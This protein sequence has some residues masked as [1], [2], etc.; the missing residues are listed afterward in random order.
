MSSSI[1][2]C[3][4]VLSKLIR[5]IALEQSVRVRRG[6]EQYRRVSAVVSRPDLREHVERADLLRQA[7]AYPS[8]A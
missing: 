2:S 1:S 7:A 5:T 6:R 4:L 8:S 3:E